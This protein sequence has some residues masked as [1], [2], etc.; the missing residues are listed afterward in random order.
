MLE[1]AYE[2]KEHGPTE[3]KFFTCTRSNSCINISA[4]PSHNQHLTIDATTLAHWWGTSIETASHTLT[5]TMTCAVRFYPMEEFSQCFCTRQGQLCFPHLWANW[6][7]GTL[8]LSTVSKHGYQ[9][10]QLFC[11]GKDWVTVVPM[12]KKAEAG[13]SLNR[14]VPKNG[15]PKFGLHTDN[16]S[17]ESG[18]HI[19]WESYTSFLNS[20][21][22]DRALQPMDE[23]SWRWNWADRDALSENNELPPVPRALWCFGIEYTLVLCK[24]IACPGIDHWSLL[25]HFTGETLTSWSSLTLILPVCHLV[26]SKWSRW[27]RLN[28]VQIG[29]MVRPHKSM[30]SRPALLHSQGEWHLDGTIQLG[31]WP[32]MTMPSTLNCRWASSAG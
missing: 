22:A 32:L 31:Q 26:W 13:D 7:L 19:K 14:V 2:K 5:L 24:W 11:N 9:Y 23:L 28:V 12:H 30:Q 29:T 17:K 8:V 1:K 16:A 25:E 27:R 21:N 3:G 20:L 6:Y 4:T 15:I 10:G 18:N